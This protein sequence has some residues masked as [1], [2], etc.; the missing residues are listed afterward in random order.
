MS[1]LTEKLINGPDP[2]FDASDVRV[3]V[4][5]M[6]VAQE[7]LKTKYSIGLERCAT[8]GYF[9]AAIG[10][11]ESGAHFAVDLDLLAMAEEQGKSVEC[12]IDAE[13]AAVEEWFR[14]NYA[15]VK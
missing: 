4:H 6:L 12:F 11:T 10:T 3:P 14:Q 9:W 13:G 7:V 2:A 15:R 5:L 8:G 1:G